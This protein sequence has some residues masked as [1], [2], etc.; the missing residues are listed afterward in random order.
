VGE[1]AVHYVNDLRDHPALLTF[2]TYAVLNVNTGEREPRP[3]TK[4]TPAD[5]TP[6]MP[7][8]VPAA[9]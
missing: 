4:R 7:K 1:V 3:L 2:G 5:P 6:S 9:G 8:F